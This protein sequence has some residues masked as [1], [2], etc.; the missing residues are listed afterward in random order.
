MLTKKKELLGGTLKVRDFLQDH[1]LDLL[2]EAYK[3]KTDNLVFGIWGTRKGVWMKLMEHMER[4]RIKDKAHVAQLH[5]EL[6]EH[7]MNVN[8]GKPKEPHNMNP[9][10][11]P[12]YP[13]VQPLPSMQSPMTHTLKHSRH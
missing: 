4:I 3:L 12:P 8:G 5:G 9:N 1:I 11:L 7:C 2:Q 10:M 13:T 6:K